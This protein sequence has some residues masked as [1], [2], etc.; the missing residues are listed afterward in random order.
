MIIAHRGAS[1][2]APENTLMAFLLAFMQGADGIEAD[3]RLTAD[4][5]L[6]AVH[7]ED[8]RRTAGSPLRVE[9][10]PLARLREL[11]AG[12]YLGKKAQ[13][14]KV[15]TLEEILALLPAG[16][17]L[18]LEIKSGPETLPVLAQVLAATPVDPSLL[19]IASFDVQVL[20]AAHATLPA[21]PRLLL[22]ERRW[23]ERKACWLPD[24]RMLEVA[25]KSVHALGISFDTRS[26]QG[27]P[28]AVA[29]LAESGLE[30]HVW[31]V[32]RIPNARRFAEMGVASITT[33]YPGHLLEGLKS[34]VA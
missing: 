31:T 23:T 22:C 2:S 28:E 33:D 8:L 6:V 17:R 15:P 27:E 10:T 21:I 29:R 24:L 14:Q 11:D 5:R 9:R 12:K 18:F 20:A 32:N 26:L 1:S 16:K 25:A 4:Q 19:R 13:G 7:D 30:T 3:L 34:V